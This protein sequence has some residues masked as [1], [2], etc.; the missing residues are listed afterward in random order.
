M[1]EGIDTDSTMEHGTDNDNSLTLNTK[2]DS[3]VEKYLAKQYELAS[4]VKP[5]RKNKKHKS[6]KN[7]VSTSSVRTR[8]KKGQNNNIS[9]SVGCEK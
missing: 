2:A 1:D 3:D 9:P 5:G 8:W 6:P 4:Q 7:Q